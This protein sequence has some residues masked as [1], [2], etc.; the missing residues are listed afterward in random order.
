[1]TRQYIGARYVVKVYENSQDAG[2]AEWEANTSYERLVLVT[3]QNTS[4]LSKKDVPANIGN[5]ATNKGYWVSMGSFNGQISQLQER[6]EEVAN[7]LEDEI[8]TLHGAMFLTNKNIVAYGDSTIY[9]GA[10]EDSYLNYVADAVGSTFVNRAI[11]GTDMNNSINLVN[12][13]TDLNNFDVCFIGHGIAEFSSSLTKEQTQTR[14]AQL[15]NAIRNKNSHITIIFN[16]PFY[17]YRVFSTNTFGDVKNNRGMTINDFNHWCIE[18]LDQLGVPHINF[19]ERS[20]CNANT[21]TLKLLNDSGGIYVHPD[22]EFKKELASIVLNGCDITEEK[23]LVPMIDYV[24]YTTA[25]HRVPFATV[26]SRNGI[27]NGFAMKL[28][29]NETVQSST[30]IFK[31]G[32]YLLHG[33]CDN[34]ITV[35]MGEDLTL[36]VPAG[37]FDIDITRGTGAA[38]VAIIA[39]ANATF[40]NEFQLYMRNKYTDMAINGFKGYTKAT[41]VPEAGMTELI[42][43]HSH[44]SGDN[45]ILESFAVRI[46]DRTEISANDILY[47]LGNNFDCGSRTS[48]VLGISMSGNVLVLNAVGNQLKLGNV[49]ANDTY[50]FD[51]KIIAP[52][53][54]SYT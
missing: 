39:G 29:A 35:T 14:V 21:Y 23:N 36:N 32:R 46:D 6:I 16:L 24:D 47:N 20:T 10:G 26:A 22:Q 25:R 18:T 37:E 12:N 19:Y 17:I 15:I 50:F 27:F 4:Y 5:P 53:A 48:Y 45:L 52:P 31:S 43:L 49:P 33:Y 13:S 40:I 44:V 11:P 1:M 38:P 34:P 8:D 2:S 28:N 54:Q 9:R 42:E 3:Y 30:K 51:A 7:S 41:F